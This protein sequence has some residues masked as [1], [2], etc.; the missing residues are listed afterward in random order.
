MVR[1]FSELMVHARQQSIELDQNRNGAAIRGAA[2]RQPESECRRRG[3]SMRCARASSSGPGLLRT[4]AKSP[5]GQA[6]ALCSAMQV[7]ARLVFSSTGRGNWDTARASAL[8]H[9]SIKAHA[10]HG[11]ASK[12]FAWRVCL[13]AVGRSR[14]GRSKYGLTS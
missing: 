4:L 10:P 1:S 12:P 5:E 8:L 13:H 9:M 14:H 7:I 3:V 11:A 6:A 2:L